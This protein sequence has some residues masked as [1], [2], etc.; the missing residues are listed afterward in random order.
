MVGLSGGKTISSKKDLS[1]GPIYWIKFTNIG[2]PE[3]NPKLKLSK[4]TPLTLLSSRT[5][6]P[7]NVLVRTRLKSDPIIFFV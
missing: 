5:L 4:L 6:N 2:Q 1:V 3:V 7:L